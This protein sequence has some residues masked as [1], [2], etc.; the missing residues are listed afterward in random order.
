MLCMTKIQ[1]SKILV[2]LYKEQH[3]HTHTHKGWEGVAGP[4]QKMAM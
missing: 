3:T 4:E 2:Y 1:N